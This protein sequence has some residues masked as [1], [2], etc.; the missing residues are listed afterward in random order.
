MSRPRRASRR[1]ASRPVLH[2]RRAT[3]ASVALVHKLRLRI[4]SAS[5]TAFGTAS[6]GDARV[7]RHFQTAPSPPEMMVLP[8]LPGVPLGAG[9]PCMRSSMA[10]I[11]GFSELPQSARSTVPAP[12][13]SPDSDNGASRQVLS[14]T[15]GKRNH[16]ALPLAV[17]TLGRRDRNVRDR[18][19][20]LTNL[21]S[22]F[23]RVAAPLERRRP[24]ET[25]SPH[26]SSI[27]DLPGGLRVAA[28]ICRRPR[29]GSC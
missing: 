17:S 25:S 7:R 9:Q 10:S 3:R 14:C 1:Y 27:R 18:G 19:H 15:G 22:P 12:S 20:T 6:V 26:R 16:L 21:Y 28:T 11:S 5:A 13:R 2:L 24:S 23:G 29:R 8:V 4:S